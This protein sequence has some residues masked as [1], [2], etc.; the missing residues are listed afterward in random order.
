MSILKC[1]APSRRSQTTLCD[2]SYLGTYAADRQS[3][4]VE[5]FVEPARR[6]QN[7]KFII[8]GAQYPRRFS[9]GRNIFFLPP[10]ATLGASGVF[11]VVTRN[12]KRHAQSDGRNGLVPFGPPLR[13]GRLRSAD[14]DRLVGRSRRLFRT[15]NREILIA[16]NCEEAIAAVERSPRRAPHTRRSRPRTRLE[17]THFRS[18]SPGF[19][20]RPHWA[21][22]RQAPAWRVRPKRPRLGLKCTPI[23]QHILVG[24]VAPRAHATLTRTRPRRPYTPRSTTLRVLECGSPSCRFG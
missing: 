21:W 13:S 9:V 11:L 16:R 22:D 14:C 24:R 4:L 15:P 23:L 2:F 8:G 3:A 18:S 20:K 19:R 1:T 7:R 5:L 17:R 10:L 6:L 12:L